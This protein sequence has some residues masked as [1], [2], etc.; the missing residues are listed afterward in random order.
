MKS[1]VNSTNNAELP[2]RIDPTSLPYPSDY[3]DEVTEG[4]PA[5]VAGSLIS[6]DFFSSKMG[7]AKPKKEDN[8]PDPNKVGVFS[9][10][11]NTS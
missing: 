2:S 6:E 3:T 1:N 4:A 10:Y 8:K 11:Q 9:P 7:T 5:G